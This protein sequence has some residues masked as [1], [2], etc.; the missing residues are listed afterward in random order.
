MDIQKNELHQMIRDYFKIY[1]RGALGADFMILSADA[2]ESSCN[3]SESTSKGAPENRDV[4][5]F[6]IS[7]NMAIHIS[8]DLEFL[9]D[10]KVKDLYRNILKAIRWNEDHIVTK[11]M[12]PEEW[13]SLDM[14]SASWSR[15]WNIIFGLNT[16]QFK[17]EDPQLKI[18][19]VPSLQE[20]Q[21]DINKKKEAWAKLKPLAQ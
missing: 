21:V 4:L 9:K 13:A 1:V 12:S 20:M 5:D 19:G 16:T 14:Q 10:P 3:L 17:T 6:R 7:E 8:S 2:A 11:V 18:V 15:H